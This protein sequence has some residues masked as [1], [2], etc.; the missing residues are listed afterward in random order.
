[1]QFSKSLFLFAAVITGT[2]YVVTV[3]ATPCG[4]VGSRAPGTGKFSQVSPR[5]F[6]QVDSNKRA[7]DTSVI[8]DVATAMGEMEDADYYRLMRKV[9]EDLAFDRAQGEDL[10]YT[11][12]EHIIQTI[13]AA[14]GGGQ[15]WLIEVLVNGCIV[16]WENSQWVVR[17]VVSDFP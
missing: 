4:S 15:H 13:Y 14:P 12:M 11:E 5:V 10:G 17:Q 6:H 1:M 2:S 16:R 3:S 7:I 9:V 8:E